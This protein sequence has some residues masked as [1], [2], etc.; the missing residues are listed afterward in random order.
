M[1]EKL[2]LAVA[3]GTPALMLLVGGA[4][5]LLVPGLRNMILTRAGEA[6]FRGSIYRAGYELFYT[7]I[8]SDDRRAVKSLIDVGVDRTGDIIGATITQ[9]V[10]W[11]PQ[12]GQTTVLLSL[13]MGCAGVA[14]L[15]ASRLTRGYEE[16]LEKS[17][18][19][20]AVELDLSEIE[21]LITRTAIVRALGSST[22]TRPVTT[23][24]DLETRRLRERQPGHACNRRFRRPADHDP[25]IGGQREY[26]SRASK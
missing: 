1:L 21:D 17:L 11:I 14:L 22:M 7:P 15:I 5:T 6:V 19:S 2:G 20:R 24:H 25:A 23:H 13:A 18:L 4:A 3:T 8:A 10:L 9:Q 16:A 26:S 12:P